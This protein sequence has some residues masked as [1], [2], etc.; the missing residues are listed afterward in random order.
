MKQSKRQWDEY[1]GQRQQGKAIL[2]EAKYL[3][4]HIL[5]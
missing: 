3:Y 4:A 1:T 5:R 2:P